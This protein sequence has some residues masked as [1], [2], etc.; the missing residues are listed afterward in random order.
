M[1]CEIQGGGWTVTLQG[2]EIGDTTWGEKKKKFN[3]ELLF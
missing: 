1:F 2:G 3:V